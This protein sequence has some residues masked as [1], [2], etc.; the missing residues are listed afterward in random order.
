V[1]GFRQFS[2]RGLAKVTAEHNLVFLALNLHRMA[3]KMAYE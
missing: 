1:L 2:L 3:P